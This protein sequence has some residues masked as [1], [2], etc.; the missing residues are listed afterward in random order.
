MTEVENEAFKDDNRI[1][2][3]LIEKDEQAVKNIGDPSV[4]M[5]VFDTEKEENITGKAFEQGLSGDEFEQ[6]LEPKADDFD[7]FAEDWFSTE[8][9]TKTQNDDPQQQ[10]AETTSL[11]SSD[12]NYLAKEIQRIAER[13]QRDRITQLE[14]DD[15]KQRVAFTAP[16]SLEQRFK[17]LSKEIWPKDGHFILSAE[18]QAIECAIKE[19][20]QSEKSWPLVHY[21]WE[22]HPVFQWLN[23]KVASHLKRQQAPVI[24]VGEK[25]AQDEQIF[26]TYSL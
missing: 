6:Q 14:T 11:F 2:E 10:L 20:R 5:G 4:F 13:E 26:I 9:E 21:L 23:N 7:F 24:K 1:L 22:Q 15:K 3:I 8:S 16:L 18:K 19:S 12:Y 25:L 17:H